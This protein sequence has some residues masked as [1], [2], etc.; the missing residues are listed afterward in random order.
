M[1]EKSSDWQS[2][3]VGKFIF[4]VVFFCF[5]LFFYWKVGLGHGL[6]LHSMIES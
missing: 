1:A 2:E 4:T 6:K 3:S 5:V